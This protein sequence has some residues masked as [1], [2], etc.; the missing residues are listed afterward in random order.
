MMMG[1]PDYIAPEQTL[2]AA[3][4]D[5]RAD[6]YSLGCTLYYLLTGSPPFKGRSQFELLQAHHSTE[7][8]PLDRLRADVPAEL[9]AVVAKMMAKDPARRYQKPVEV[10]QALAPFVKAGG[11]EPRRS[12]GPSAE[13][14]KPGA[15]PAAT[16]PLVQCTVVE[17]SATVARGINHA[18]AGQV[19]GH[20]HPEDRDEFPVAEEARRP[21]EAA[22]GGS[23]SRR[24]ARRVAEEARRQG[25]AAALWFLVA[26]I[27]NLAVMASSLPFVLAWLI[28]VAR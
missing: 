15:T 23:R 10:A 9:A 20:P 12:P 28:R 4:A 2:D 7:A 16:A 11:D 13:A 24:R 22:A 18:A 3:R 21:G 19:W 5:I 14:T 17:G 8:T 1:T 27:G 26:G 6:I 25:E